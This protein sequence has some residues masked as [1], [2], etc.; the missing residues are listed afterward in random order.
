VITLLND[1]GEPM[2]NSL[3]IL[4]DLETVDITTTANSDYP[5]LFVSTSIPAL[6]SSFTQ[7]IP[8]IDDN[9]NEETETMELV[10]TII[11]GEISNSSPVLRGLGTIKDNDIP[12]LFSPNNDGRSDVF[13]IDGIE[14][15]PNFKLVIFDRWG[16]EIYNYRNNGNPSPN[17]WDG[18]NNGNPVIEGVY[19]YT[20]D[21]NDGVTKP[22]TGFIQLVR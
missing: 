7:E 4:F 1:E 19:F 18:T 14:D 9:L 22:K 12:N 10:A 15:F 5:Y 11:A 2:R 13:R 20:L 3:P 17:W 16:G 6:N 21:Y 8:T